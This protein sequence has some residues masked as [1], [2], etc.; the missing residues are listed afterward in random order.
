MPIPSAKLRTLALSSGVIELY[1]VAYKSNPIVRFAN[2]EETGSTIVY[3]GFTYTCA[4]IG[5][6]GVGKTADGT[7][8][9]PSIAVGNTNRTIAGIFGT[10]DLVGA[11]ITRIITLAEYLDGQ[12][13]ANTANY[14]STSFI[15]EQKASETYDQITYSLATPLEVLGKKLPRQQATQ[16]IFPGVGR[17]VGF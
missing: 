13:G 14:Q 1:E 17:Y 5:I 11:K 9:R 10:T 8:P 12:P 4:P 15:V 16:T 6:T 7:L 2:L 3:R